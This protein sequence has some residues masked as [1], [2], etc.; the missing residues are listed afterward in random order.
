MRWTLILL[1]LQTI[2]LSSALATPRS[3]HEA[4]QAAASAPDSEM[5]IAGA[6]ALGIFAL[7]RRR[8]A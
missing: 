5:Y 8:V 6:V 3:I 4:M 1:G 7:A 2:G